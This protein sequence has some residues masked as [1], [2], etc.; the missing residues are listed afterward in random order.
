VKVFLLAVLTAG[1][2][3][4]GAAVL[5]QGQQMTVVESYTTPS[6]RVGE[7]GENLIVDWR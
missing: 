6:A 3:S 2:L 1:A 4:A 7:P 5:L